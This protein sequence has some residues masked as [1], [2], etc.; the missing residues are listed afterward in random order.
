ME[1]SVSDLT[2]ILSVWTVIFLSS[3]GLIQDLCVCV[4]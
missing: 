2:F 3:V 1:Q 4:D